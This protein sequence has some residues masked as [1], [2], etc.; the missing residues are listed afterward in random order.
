[1]TFDRKPL[2]EVFVMH[3]RAPR[4]FQV[5]TTA[6]DLRPSLDEVHIGQTSFPR[7]FPKVSQIDFKTWE[8][9]RCGQR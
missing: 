8:R 7:S 2:D 6:F 1:V 3:S 9:Q 4:V 5:L